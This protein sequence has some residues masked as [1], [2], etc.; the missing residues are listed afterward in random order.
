VFPLIWSF[1]N[2]TRKWLTVL[3][4]FSYGKSFKEE[5][6]HLV[7]TPLFWHTYNYGNY[8]TFL[9]PVYWK[10]KNELVNNTTIF[11]IY[12]SR[13]NNEFTKKVLFPIIWSY[14]DDNYRSFTFFPLYSYGIS[15]AGP[16]NHLVI[17]PLYWRVNDKNSEKRVLFPVYFHYKFEED[18][19][20]VKHGDTSFYKYLDETTVLF[21]IYYLQKIQNSRDT[22]FNQTVFPV[23]WKRQRNHYDNTTIFPF[24]WSK[25]NQFEQTQYFLPFVINYK[26]KSYKSFTLLPLFSRGYSPNGLK[27]HLFIFPLFLPT[28]RYKPVC[29]RGVSFLQILEN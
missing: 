5:K 20:K 21:P 14:R 25:K 2:D 11:P 15:E 7:I 26:S 12:W 6:S 19:I 3:P 23:Y 17:T 27:S 8:R 9:F 22:I 16:K 13:E 28:Q 1:K 24:Y 4:I 10:F 29:T 18:R